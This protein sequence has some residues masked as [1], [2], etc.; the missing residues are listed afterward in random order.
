M[1]RI[2]DS[3]PSWVRGFYSTFLAAES[4]GQQPGALQ[5]KWDRSWIRVSAYER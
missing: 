3:A 4:F 2:P 5:P 1:D